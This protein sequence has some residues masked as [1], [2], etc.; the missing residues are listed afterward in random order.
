MKDGAKEN[1]P[2]GLVEVTEPAYTTAD[3]G[4]N[5]RYVLKAAS[6]YAE[7]SV[8][9]V[10]YILE[11]CE[12]APTPSFTFLPLSGT[13]SIGGD[14][15]LTIPKNTPWGD[16]KR[17]F[18]AR[19]TDS[20]GTIFNSYKFGIDFGTLDPGN[21]QSG[22]Y[23]ISYIALSKCPGSAGATRFFRSVERTVVVSP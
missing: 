13:G 7:G 23:K 19:E 5:V 4:N 1:I 17:S 16:P 8:N 21:P 11:N 22:T 10:V 15:T 14:S 12:S 20:D 6:G 18:R 2:V 9:R 3:G